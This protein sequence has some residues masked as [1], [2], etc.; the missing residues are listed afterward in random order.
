MADVGPPHGSGGRARRTA[1]FRAQHSWEEVQIALPHYQLKSRNPI[2][3][4]TFGKVYLMEHRVSG[5]RTAV[6]ALK[7]DKI[8]EE[9]LSSIQKVRREIDLMRQIN[10]PNVI[11]LY[12]VVETA[13]FILLVTEYAQGGELYDYITDNTRLPE[14]EARRIFQQIIAGVAYC[15]HRRVV[16]RDLKPENI[17]LDENRNVKIADFGLGN[18]ITDGNFF[19]TWCGSPNYA[20]PEVVARHPYAGPESDIWSCGVVLYTL[21][22][23]RLPFDDPS[24]A[25]L[26][27]TIKRGAY[28]FP[29]EVPLTPGVVDLIARILVVDPL[30][31]ITIQEIRRH[32]WFFPWFILQYLPLLP[33]PLATGPVVQNT[34]LQLS[35]GPY[36]GEEFPGG[37]EPEAESGP[38]GVNA[39]P[40]RGHQEVDQLAGGES[41]PAH[42]PPPATAALHALTL[43]DPLEDETGE[44]TAWGV[45]DAA[46]STPHCHDR[47]AGVPKWGSGM[48]LH[49][50]AN[51]AC[52]AMQR[53]CL[54]LQGM[55]V[56]WNRMSEFHLECAWACHVAPPEA[57]ELALQRRR[58]PLQTEF[59]PFGAVEGTAPRM[60]LHRSLLTL[61]VPEPGRP[62]TLAVYPGSPGSSQ[63]FL[64]PI[65]AEVGFGPAYRQHGWPGASTNGHGNGAF[66]P[67]GEPLETNPFGQSNGSSVHLKAVSTDRNDG[68]ESDL[69]QNRVAMGPVG[70]G[71]GPVSN[72]PVNA[73]QHGAFSAFT[74]VRLGKNGFGRPPNGVMQNRFQQTALFG[75]GFGP[76]GLAY[77]MAGS[78]NPPASEKVS[79]P[80]PQRPRSAEP[81]AVGGGFRPFGDTGMPPFADQQLL[82]GVQGGPNGFALSHFGEIVPVGGDSDEFDSGT[83]GEGGVGAVFGKGTSLFGNRKAAQEVSTGEAGFASDAVRGSAGGAGGWGAFAGQRNGFASVAGGNGF[84]GFGAAKDLP[85]TE[86]LVEN[87]DARERRESSAGPDIGAGVNKGGAPRGG[88]VAGAHAAQQAAEPAHVQNRDIGYAESVPYGRHIAGDAHEASPEAP[89]SRDER[90]K[91]R[92]RGKRVLSLNG[93]MGMDVQEGYGGGR[94]LGYVNS[95]VGQAPDG[96]NGAWQ[97]RKRGY[98]PDSRA[99]RQSDP[100]AAQG[101]QTTDTG[102]IA[103]QLKMVEVRF[104]LLLYRLAPQEYVIDICHRSGPTM[105]FFELCASLTREMLGAR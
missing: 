80:L 92:K 6:K 21:V 44:S 105:Y 31:R 36:S 97:Q 82:D 94:N 61:L 91:D 69:T 28:S 49:I 63:P 37:G 47:F 23:G 1:S 85:V 55:A 83:D 50:R 75:H 73:F 72:G 29:G 98:R 88:H 46:N 22:C 57:R 14:H 32:P 78:P 48:P 18:A 62:Q 86:R 99:E 10:H 7:K 104:E 42:V 84:S 56:K 30:K 59:R 76:N 26:Y 9:G 102:Q 87:G 95:P 52:E 3:H 24:V 64:S 45:P 13:D 12:E 39:L 34:G 70:F 77:P 66:S 93:E 74:P 58:P 2:G 38:G 79:P 54:L 5:V 41:K 25:S 100:L 90:N 4:G 35:I 40:V 60:Q 51:R 8:R 89:R 20:A 67:Y 15:H 101:S 16:H 68:R 19:K 96:R 53:L 103:P 71:A 27:D 81:Y 17:L 33:P 65:S 11:R 43:G